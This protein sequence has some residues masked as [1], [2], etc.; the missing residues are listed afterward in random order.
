MFEDRD[1]YAAFYTERLWLLLPEVYRASDSDDPNEKGPL[2]EMVE[3]LGA[4]IAV[5][6]RS[7]DRTLEDQS[8]ESGDDWL[9]SY[10]GDLLSTRLVAGLGVRGQRLQVAKTI[11][12]RRRTGTV[13]LLEELAADVTGW[14]ARVVEFFRRVVRARHNFDPEIGNDRDE[15]VIA[16]LRGVLS[17]TPAGGFADLRHAGAA[18][19]TQTAFDEYF[20]TADLRGARARTGWHNIPKLGVFLWRLQSFGCRPTAPVE[21]TRCPGQFTFDPTGREIPLFARDYRGNEQYGDAWVTPDEWMLPG[22]ISAELLDRQSAHLYPD[23]A[24]IIDVAVSGETILPL[25]DARVNPERG[26]YQPVNPPLAGSLRRVRYHYGFSSE[27]GAGPYDRRSLDETPLPQP[28]PITPVSG[29]GASL[30]PALAGL[31]GTGTVSISDSLTY[32]SVADLAGISD[33][34]LQ[35]GLNERPVVRLNGGDW[36]FEG[37][38]GSILA[39]EGLFISG[40]NVILRGVFETVTLSCATL[41]PGEEVQPDGTTPQSV[42]QRPLAPATLWVEGSVN[43]LVLRRSICG[44]IRIRGGGAVSRVEAEDSIIQGVRTTLYGPLVTADLRDPHRLARILRDG[45]DPLASFLRGS[46]SAGVQAALAAYDPN[47]PLPNALRDQILAELNTLLAG[48]SIYDAQR[49]AAVPLP[50]ALATE[51]AAG[52]PPA[53]RARVTRM[54]LEAA[55]PAELAPAAIAAANTDISLERT[56]VLGRIYGHR[57]SATE[58]ILA[59]FAAAD[60]AQTGCVRFTAYVDGSRL[61]Q[62]YEGVT[63]VE[64]APIFGTRRFGQPEYAQLSPLADR[65]IVAGQAEAAIS[66][67]AEDGSEMGAFARE[68]NPI[69]ERGLKFKL[70]EFMPVGLTPVLIRVT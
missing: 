22:R 6:R 34:L 39:I 7:I 53:E 8:I 26:R 18:Q 12:Y 56:T 58:C 5:V 68:K 15:A 9:V 2:R 47:D 21:D 41:D 3:R 62:P 16:G 50:P 69:K 17:G 51:A 29:G 55:Y 48:A 57:I 49:F 43:R 46:F 28:A 37:A 13:G 36:V 60:D 44:P 10:Q 67:G 20:H 32:T 33:I 61:R 52:P 65:E 23:S 25:L 35:A 64:E 1:L 59:S 4:Q 66:A 42:D 24:A 30:Q 63:I 11:Y 19:N 70:G 45:S 40:P 31:G 38:A 27:I 54:L 14:N